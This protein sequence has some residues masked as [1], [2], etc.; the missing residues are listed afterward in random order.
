MEDFKYLHQTLR[1]AWTKYVYF[2]LAAS[3][4]AVAFAVS[5][6]SGESLTVSQLPLGFAV[7]LWGLS[8]FFGCRSI[9]HRNES[10]SVNA[11]GVMKLMERTY[12]AGLEEEYRKAA[13]FLDDKAAK[14]MRWQFGYFIAGALSFLVWHVI[15]MANTQPAAA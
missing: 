1:E 10:L 4:S 15:E 9:W 13:D 12:V 5:I 3:A 2:L 7:A 8:F 11:S 6:T 14:Y